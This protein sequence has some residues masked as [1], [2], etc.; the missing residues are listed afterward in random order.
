MPVEV[1][2]F[3]RFV[4]AGGAIAMNGWGLTKP[5]V[6]HKAKVRAKLG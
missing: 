2:L 6:G 5:N 4:T 3:H 1:A